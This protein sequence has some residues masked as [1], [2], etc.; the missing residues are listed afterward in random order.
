MNLLLLSESIIFCSF[1]ILLFGH[2]DSISLHKPLYLIF[3]AY[4]FLRPS[5]FVHTS[6]E[7]RWMKNGSVCMPRAFNKHI[8]NAA[9][10]IHLFTYGVSSN[11]AL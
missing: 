7:K 2:I 8:H 5:V 1:F 9:S 6:L 11:F 3:M 10:L 4:I